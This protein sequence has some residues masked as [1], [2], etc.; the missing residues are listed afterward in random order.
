LFQSFNVNVPVIIYFN[1]LLGGKCVLLLIS[2][3]VNRAVRFT[4]HR[5]IKRY[6]QSCEIARI[7]PGVCGVLLYRS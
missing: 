6:I 5:F 4:E 3:E 1:T 7:G 2:Q